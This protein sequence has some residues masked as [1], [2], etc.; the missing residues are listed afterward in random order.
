MIQSQN[1]CIQSQTDCL[2]SLNRLEGKVSHLVNT[3]ND[4]NKETLPNTFRSLLI[5]PAI[6]TKN[7]GILEILTMTHH[8]ISPKNFEL[9][10]Y[11]LIDELASFHFNEIELE[12]EYD[13]DSQC[14]DSIS[15][16]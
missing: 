14:C 8:S 1:D 5:L 12:E 13:T 11:Q 3:I 9:G 7:H 16:F 2:K 4:R 10:Q 15:L 6:L